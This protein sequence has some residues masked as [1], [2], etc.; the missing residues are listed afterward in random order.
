MTQSSHFTAPN[1]PCWHNKRMKDNIKN[2]LQ[3][4]KTTEVKWTAEHTWTEHDVLKPRETELNDKWGKLVLL[5]SNFIISSNPGSTSFYLS[6]SFG[7]VLVFSELNA[8]YSSYVI[9]IQSSFHRNNE[10]FIALIHT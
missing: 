4:T 7:S 10:V 3:Y 6:G 8:M 1:I 2:I 9:Y 5:I